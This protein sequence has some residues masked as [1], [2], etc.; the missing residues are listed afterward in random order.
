MQVQLNQAADVV[1][2]LLIVPK[3]AAHNTAHDE[4]N[5]AKTIGKIA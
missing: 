2:A 1:H 5:T 4:W 3:V